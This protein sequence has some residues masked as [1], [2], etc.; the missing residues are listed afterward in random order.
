MATASKKQPTFVTERL[1]V[2]PFRATDLEAMHALYGDA[3]NLRYWSV[4]PSANLAA[5]RRMMRWHLVYRPRH[6]VMWAV[7]EKKSRTVAGMINYHH[8][9]LREKRVDVGWLL[10]PAFQGKGYMA[11]AGRVLLGHLFDDLGVHKVEALIQPE[12]KP[13]AA[14]ARRLGFR[15]EGGPIRDRWLVDG[16]WHSVMLYGLVAGEG[17]HTPDIRSRR[18]SSPRTSRRR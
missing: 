11:E 4:P 3:D 9:N 18:G 12:N 8:R 13:S 14:L 2:R 15:L 7:E 16:R 1:R 5:T 6:Y 10:L 17:R